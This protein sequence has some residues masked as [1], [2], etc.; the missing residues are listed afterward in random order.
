MHETGMAIQAPRVTTARILS[1]RAARVESYRDW[2]VITLFNH[3][4]LVIVATFHL[5]T[6]ALVAAALL[7]GAGFAL[8]AITVLHGVR[9]CDGCELVLIPGHI[10]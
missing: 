3:S 5:P 9:L 4:V 8:G 6:A 2:A 1:G 7:L 10:G